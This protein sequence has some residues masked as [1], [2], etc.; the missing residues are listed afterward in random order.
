MH[1]RTGFSLDLPGE[2]LYDFGL[3]NPFKYAVLA[4]DF[5]TY[6]AAQWT[7]NETQAGAT[8]AISAGANGGILVMTNTAADNDQNSIQRIASGVTGEHFR[9]AA[10]RDS[11]FIARFSLDGTATNGEVIIGLQITDSTPLDTTDGIFFLKPDASAVM[12]LL[13]EK[14]NTATTTAAGTVVSATFHEVAWFYSASDGLFH[15]FFDGREVGTSVAT[16][17]P[18]DEDLTVTLC[19]V[20]GSANARVLS[21]DYFMSAISR[22]EN[23][24]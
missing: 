6:T 9:W 16:N 3:P 1:S 19:Q 11:C 4:E 10:N 12:S 13:V 7:V 17:A 8:Q 18:N 21:V 14:D 22:V 2:P 23:W 5:M 20:N 15:I 24:T